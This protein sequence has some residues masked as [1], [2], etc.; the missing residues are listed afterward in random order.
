MGTSLE[1]VLP[2]PCLK[3]PLRLALV[4]KDDGKPSELHDGPASRKYG[5]GVRLARR[6]AA[7]GET[8][9]PR[10]SVVGIGEAEVQKTQRFSHEIPALP[11]LDIKESDKSYVA[12]CIPPRID[13]YGETVGEAEKSM[14]DSV[15]YFL[16]QNFS[17]LSFDDAWENLRD[18]FKA[19][20]WSNELWGAYH[21]AQ[22]QIQ[23]GAR[24]QR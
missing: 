8:R 4:V 19:D 5:I 17:K 21:E 10:G 15:A 16:R 24:G 12:T 20:E 23:M 9:I 1:Q 6:D 2:K 18:L 22:L 13:G 11:F 14:A 3:C 7:G